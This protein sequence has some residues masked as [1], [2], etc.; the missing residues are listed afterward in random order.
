MSSLGA[1]RASRLVVALVAVRGDHAVA[2]RV[3]G[4]LVDPVALAL[5]DAVEVELADRDD[6][7]PVSPVDLV[8]VDVERVGKA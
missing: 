5:G 7:V 6:D 3:D 8:A 4:V 2:V 1:G